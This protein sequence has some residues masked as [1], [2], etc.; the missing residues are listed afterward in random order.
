M[1]IFKSS[2]YGDKERV[3][4]CLMCWFFKFFIFKSLWFFGPGVVGAGTGLILKHRKRLGLAD[5]S[6]YAANYA[7]M[8]GCYCGNFYI[9]S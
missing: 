3:R 7:I 8:T 2:F 6:A 4:V 5:V 9:L 1:F